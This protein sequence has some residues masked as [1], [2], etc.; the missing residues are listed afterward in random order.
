MSDDAPDSM[1]VDTERAAFSTG[2]E[3]NYVKGMQ[4]LTGYENDTNLMNITGS[5][6]LFYYSY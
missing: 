4:I 3:Q 6:V 1:T 2:D 5:G